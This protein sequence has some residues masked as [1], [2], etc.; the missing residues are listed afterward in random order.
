MKITT[1][2]PTYRR[3]EMLKGCL[4]A[5]QKQIRLANEV[6]VIVRDHDDETWKFLNTIQAN[7]PSMVAH[8]VTRP[9]VIAALNIGL[10]YAKGD[11]IAF[12]DD[13]AEPHQD[14]LFKIERYFVDNPSIGGVGG[15]DWVYFDSVLEDRPC[16]IVGKIQWYGHVIGNHHIGKGEPRDVDVLKGV[17][18]SFRHQAIAGLCF[19]ERLKGDGA[20][21]DF[22]LAICLALKKRSWRIIYDPN[23]GV[24]HYP[25]QRHDNDI[26][27]EFNDVALANA[28]HN[29]TLSLLEYLSPPRRFIFFIW[30]IMIGV[31]SARGFIQFLRFIPTE[32]LLSGQKMMSSFKGRWQGIQSWLETTSRQHYKSINIPK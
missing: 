15:R 25:A 7:F 10:K 29:Q 30:T 14:W 16:K 13:D 12:T 4:N 27:G 22:E 1:I 17:N 19:D 24:N 21:V 11:I 18:M 23:I 20:Q 28:V 6:L 5:L 31:S 8:Q 2:I 9:G 3:P 32:G 26:R